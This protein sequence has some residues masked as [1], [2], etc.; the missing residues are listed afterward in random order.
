MDIFKFC[1]VV[2]TG[3][4]DTEDILYRHRAGFNPEDVITILQVKIPPA[5]TLDEVIQQRSQPADIHWCGDRSL[6]NPNG[7]RWF[8]W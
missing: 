8:S 6:Q 2:S 4:Q 5:I 3:L 7:F 1:A